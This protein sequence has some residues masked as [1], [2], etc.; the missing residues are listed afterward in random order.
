MTEIIY[1]ALKERVQVF[2]PIVKIKDVAEVYARKRELTQEIKELP[3]FVFATNQCKA[4]KQKGTLLHLRDK[5]QI[6]GML[7]IVQVIQTSKEQCLVLPTGEQ[8]CIVELVDG[9]K[10]K[11][12]WEVAKLFFVCLL[13]MAGG[14]FSIMA[15]H[16]DIS[17]P[18]LFQ[19]FYYFIMGTK[20]DGNTILELFY[21]LGLGLGIMLFYNHVGKRRITKDPTPIEVSMRSYEQQMNAAMVEDWEREGKVIDVN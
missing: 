1:I 12:L 8:N 4:K 2:T 11:K 19:K 14:A 6:I 18:I 9:K 15:F 5:R 3:L 17:L 13:C 20:S 10:K 21:S 7:R 16:N